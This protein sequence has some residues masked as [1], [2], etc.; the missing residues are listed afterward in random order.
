MSLRGLPHG[1][2]VNQAY[3]WEAQ[4]DDGQAD[5]L[6]TAKEREAGAGTEFQ[7]VL[8]ADSSHQVPPEPLSD[9]ADHTEKEAKGEIGQQWPK[10][11]GSN[12]ICKLSTQRGV[13]LF[14]VSALF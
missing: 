5:P 4:N 9:T 8:S 10:Q 12:T 2:L 11:G 7:A 3:S 13:S 14:P 1:G 6:R